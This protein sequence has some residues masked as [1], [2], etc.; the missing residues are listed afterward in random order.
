MGLI[1]I[2]CIIGISYFFL[3]GK[4]NSITIP[5]ASSM[6]TDV[7]ESCLESIVCPDCNVILL[8]VDSLRADHT[9]L[10]GYHRD[11]TPFLKE[12]AN[13]SQ[14]FSQYITTTHLTI[15]TEMSLHTGMYPS[16]SGFT[17]FDSTLR[18]GIDTIASV[19]RRNG[20]RTYAAHSSPEFLD[21]PE[22]ARSFR[23]DYH[24]YMPLDQRRATGKNLDYLDSIITDIRDNKFLLWVTIG[25]VHWPFG[26][27]LPNVFADPD[28]QGYWSNKVV[29]FPEVQY[30][31]DRVKYP[32]DQETQQTPM[33]DADLHHVIDMYDNGIRDF[34][35]FVSEFMNVLKRRGID[36][37]TILVISSEHGEDMHD[38]KYFAHYDIHDSQI[39]TPLLMYVPGYQ[40]PHVVDTPTSTVD[41]LPTILHILGIYPPAQTQGQTMLPYLCQDRPPEP[42]R[43]TFTER[44][45]QW[46]RVIWERPAMEPYRDEILK[47]RPDEH[48]IAIRSSEWKYVIRRSAPFL[49]NISWWSATAGIT[50][51]Y[52]PEELFRLSVDPGETVNVAAQYPDIVND[53]RSRL[54]IQWD[55]I[56]RPSPQPQRGRIQEYF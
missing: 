11:T 32:N 46:E 8:S 38:H 52:P 4:L 19:L 2:I 33:T 10:L 15:T 39:H 36:E 51:N 43:Y 1:I 5:L 29:G 12:L 7:D 54:L 49:R 53:L 45:P 14:V 24:W 13:K 34:D 3:Y 9:S 18:E 50:M 17:Q 55:R 30:I 22:V 44:V 20:F 21:R 47:F 25:S 16:S 40:T 6:R 35:V 48:D 27:G 28:Y 41:V 31:Y 26:Y 42:D 37:K 56:Y 23:K